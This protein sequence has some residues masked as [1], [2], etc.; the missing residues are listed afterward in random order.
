M[1]IAVAIV[2]AATTGLVSILDSHLISKRMPSFLSFLAPIGVVHFVLGLVVLTILPLP[3]GVDTVTLAVA[4]GSSV[5]RVVGALLMLRTMRSEEVSRI[6]PVTNTFPIFVAL[7]AV[8]VLG[9]DLGWLEWL[10]IIITVSGAVLISVRWGTDGQGI[11]LRRSFAVLMV[12]SILFGV[13]N[14][15]SKYAM[16][17]LTFWNMYGINSSCLGAIFLLLSVRRATLREI[18][19]MTDRNS[20]LGLILFNECLAV[21][22]FVLS[23][24]AIEQG[25]VSMV[26]TI[27][28]T[29]PAFVFVYALAVSRFF[30]AVLD[31][32]LSRGI[33]ATKLVSIGL[34]IGGVTLLTTG[35]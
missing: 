3:A 15:G 17:Q 4:V 12:S 30:P 13:A 31:E 25:P 28:S 18:G 26:S 20:V 27:L 11:R 19:D 24:R 10:A 32:H 5:I 29:R 2:S 35:G 14:V 34:I 21:V 8:P 16:E 22:G 1:W 7:L 9:E 6:M 23:F 33:I